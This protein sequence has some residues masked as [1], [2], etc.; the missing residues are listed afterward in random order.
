MRIDCYQHF[1]VAEAI[2]L[3]LKDRETSVSV[4]NGETARSS[5]IVCV[6][7]GLASELKVREKNAQV[8]V[9]GVL[10]IF[11]DQVEA[12]FNQIVELRAAMTLPRD[13]REKC[14]RHLAYAGLE[15]NGGSL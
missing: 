6:T 13:L 1:S 5:D 8:E 11:L 4:A 3:Q 12:N 10:G 14:A 9:P 15:K 2:G 7:C